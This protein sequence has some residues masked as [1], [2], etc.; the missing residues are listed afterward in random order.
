MRLTSPTRAR[1]S[2][3]RRYDGVVIG[4]PPHVHVAKAL[5]R[6]KRGLPVLLE[7]PVAPDLASARR[8]AAVV[9]GASAPC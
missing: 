6:S 8:L 5:P 2:P 1:R 4:S 7:K 3:H 9:E